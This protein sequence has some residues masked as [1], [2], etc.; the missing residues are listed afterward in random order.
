VPLCLLILKEKINHPPV[1]AAEKYTV[2]SHFFRLFQFV[3]DFGAGQLA[4]VYASMV[5]SVLT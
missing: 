1:P 3:T 2:R 5:W 4:P